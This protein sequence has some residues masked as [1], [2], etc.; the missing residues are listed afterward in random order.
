MR[1]GVNLSESLA[2][3]IT[4]RPDLST[5]SWPFEL[6]A[7]RGANV[8]LHNDILIEAMLLAGGEGARR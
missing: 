5:C 6:S 3:S 7:S 1:A 4:S 8:W 2:E